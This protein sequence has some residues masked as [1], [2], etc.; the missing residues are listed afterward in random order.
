MR[1][2]SLSGSWLVMMLAAG[3]ATADSALNQTGLIQRGWAPHVVLA[4]EGDRYSAVPR[5]RDAV[6]MQ[7]DLLLRTRMD[8]D[9]RRLSDQFWTHIEEFDLKTLY[10]FLPDQSAQWRGVAIAG[11][12]EPGSYWLRRDPAGMSVLA[13]NN[14]KEGSLA[15]GEVRAALALQ[16]LQDIRGARYSFKQASAVGVGDLEWNSVLEAG[17]QTLMILSR[18]A[19][20][21]KSL[22]HTQDVKQMAPQLSEQDQRIVAALWSAFP[23]SWNA[24]TKTA[25]VS[26]VTASTP[27]QNGAQRLN[28]RFVGDKQKLQQH[29]P[30]VAAYLERMGDVMDAS[31]IIQNTNGQWLSLQVNSKSMECE[32]DMWLKDG[33][34]IPARNGE[35]VL[36]SLQSAWTK[37]PAWQANIAMRFRALGVV[38][39]LNDWHMDWRYQQNP[40][41]AIFSGVMKDKPNVSIDGRAL[42]VM[43]ASWLAHMPVDIYKI[44][45][46][47]MSVLVD[48]NNGEG[49]KISL[50]FDERD[51]ERSQLKTT[52][53]WDGLDNF[54]VRM[55]VSMV[56]DKMIP[57]DA[58]A[59]EIRGLLFDSQ[60]AF[61]RDLENFASSVELAKATP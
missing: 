61:A 29:Y 23:N 33:R 28:I 50:A 11:T 35:P 13:E 25:T 7:Q 31:V 39:T 6:R 12:P 54:F 59:D 44:V 57:D 46:D 51:A 3:T 34:I 45:D 41:T 30:K 38:T 1:Q 60:I 52:A 36:D 20:P 37:Q 49:A 14:A 15:F 42:G 17:R 5:L 55:G 9:T 24:F 47:F 53:A 19:G 8:A 56:V 22:V 27:Q 40:N 32:V 26:R 48:S 4:G 43:P 10:G 18:D 2:F 58:T 21:N 16:P